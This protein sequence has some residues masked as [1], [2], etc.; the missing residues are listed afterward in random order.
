MSR[1][2]DEIGL[3]KKFFVMIT[4]AA[5][6]VLTG[7]ESFITNAIISRVRVD[8]RAIFTDALLLAFVCFATFICLFVSLLAGGTVAAERA[9]GVDARA[10]LAQ[11]GNRLAFV[12][13]FFFVFCFFFNR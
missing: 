7:Y 8:T 1:P 9:D 2:R 12:N 13:I 6:P 5:L 4:D 3:K 11:T 10:A